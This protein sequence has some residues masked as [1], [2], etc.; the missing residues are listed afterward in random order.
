MRGS[1]V[2]RPDLYDAIGTTYS[3]TRRADA[4]LATRIRA[5]VGDGGRVINV[6]A[7]TGSYEPDDCAVI[8][9]EPSMV[10]ISQRSDGAAPA[11]QATAESLPFRDRCFDV[12]MALWTIHHWTDLPRGVAELRRVAGRTVI[13]THSSVTNDLWVTSDYWP[14][15]AL[16]RRDHI[17]LQAL[18]DLLGGNARIELLP[19]PRDCTDGSGESFWARPEAYLDSRVRAGMSSFQLLGREDLQ[20]GLERL[21]SDLRSGV[22]DRRYGHLRDAEQ[23]D[24]GMRLIVTP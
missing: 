13:V 8:A 19:L 11:V 21:D 6:G 1:I 12:A 17:Q 22:W 7:G 2:R 15:M 3:R 5:A 20:R 10:M 23:W 18:V 14:G 24:C 16:Q 9:V 4:R